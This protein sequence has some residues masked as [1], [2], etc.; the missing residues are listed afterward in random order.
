MLKAIKR[1]LKY[2][3]WLDYQFGDRVYT[4]TGIGTVNVCY[5][6]P[7]GRLPFLR[8]EKRPLWQVYMDDGVKFPPHHANMFRSNEM[9]YIDHTS[10]EELLTHHCAT[11]R[12]RAAK[13]YGK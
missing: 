2:Q 4:S 11:I 7:M 9:M 10:V 6:R 13:L 8:A 12:Y 3:G 1:W 5:Y